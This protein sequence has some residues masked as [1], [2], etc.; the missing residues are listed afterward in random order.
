[1][2]P[3]VIGA[4]LRRA[5]TARGLTQEALAQAVGLSRSGY[6]NMERGR[7]LPRSQSLHDLARALDVPLGQLL[8]AERKLERV[9]LRSRKCMKIRDSILDRV[10]RWL[11]DF[12]SLEEALGEQ[13]RSVLAEIHRSTDQKGPEAL[14]AATRQVLRL[15]AEEPI[16]DICGLLEDR[17]GVKVLSLQDVA[18]DTFF[19]LAV[20]EEDGGPAVVVNAWERITVER[21]IFTAAHELG[22]LVL[23][24]EA[25]EVDATDEEP[26]E[27]KEAD[28]FATFFLM[29]DAAFRREW[30]GSAGGPFL[31]RVLKVKRIFHVS[32]ATVLYR[33]GHTHEERRRLFQQ[34]HT[35]YKRT[36]GKSLSKKD[37]PLGLDS[38]FFLKRGPV[39]HVEPD[40]LLPSDFVEDRFHRLAIRAARRGEI[41]QSRAAEML[42]ISTSDVRERIAADGELG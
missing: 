40:Q 7:T 9:R 21:W 17:G 25:F 5:R 20:G 2:K 30:E 14:A 42:G 26:E 31:Q 11:A 36:A 18:T 33:L 15:G 16:R 1:M 3:E 37:E 29:P 27:E 34:F 22:H 6:R 19:G 4:N 24:T 12:A 28:R 8:R 23:H 38:D 41:S 10:D 39:A 35:L 13:S 32:Y